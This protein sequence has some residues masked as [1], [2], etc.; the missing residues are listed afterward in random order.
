MTSKIAARLV[1]V[2]EAETTSFTTLAA[3]G[4]LDPKR[5]FVNADLRGIDFGADDLAGYD[6]SGADLRGANLTCALTTDLI[7][8]AATKW[9]DSWHPPEPTELDPAEIQR[10]FAPTEAEASVVI[11]FNPTGKSRQVAMLWRVL[12]VLTQNGVRIDVAE[13]RGLDDAT[14]VARKAAERGVPMVVSAGNDDTVAAVARGLALAG[15]TTKLGIIPLGK[16]NALVRQLGLE[17]S[18][19]AIAAEIA[20][21]QLDLRDRLA[22]LH[23][24]PPESFRQHPLMHAL[25]TYIARAKHILMPL[26]IVQKMTRRSH[27]S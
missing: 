10:R 11:V 27:E 15:Q 8:S 12:D 25:K 23:R 17:S 14:H 4:Q 1:A 13:T 22:A 5:S 7:W 19:R 24:R 26:T 6:F 18:P 16:P 21:G 9:P 20:F 2:L 3:L